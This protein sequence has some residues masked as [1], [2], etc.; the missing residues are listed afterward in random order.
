[1][2]ALTRLLSTIA[3]NLPKLFY[4]PVF[5]C[6]AASKDS[7]TV[8][9]LRTIVQLSRFFPEFWIGDTEM[10][11][12]ALM[13]NGNAAPGATPRP[14]PGQLVVMMEILAH[15]KS[16]AQVRKDQVCLL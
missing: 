2:P 8:S 6:A 7:T 10:L 3:S 9:H 16:I 1:M 12:V 4:K 11:I 5:A 14:R 15:I 13:S